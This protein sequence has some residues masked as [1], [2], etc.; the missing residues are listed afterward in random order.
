MEVG[1]DV[2]RQPAKCFF[3]ARICFRLKTNLCKPREPKRVK[4]NIIG[5]GPAGL[6]FAILA[7]KQHPE[8]KITV[9]ERNQPDDTFGFGVVFSDETLSFFREAD[10]ESYNE[11]IS[12]FAYWDEIETRY[13]GQVIRTS[14]HGFCGMSRK[15][16]LQILQNRAD[17]LGVTIH[18]ESEITDPSPYQDADLVVAADGVNSQIRETYAASFNPRIDFRPNKFVWLGTAAPF[19]AFTFIFKEDRNGIWN[20]HAYR[21]EDELATLIVETTEVTWK[22]AGMDTATEAETAQFIAEL[23]AEELNGAQVL[24]NRSNW[25]AFPNIHCESWVHENIVLIGDS[26]HTAHFSIGSGTKLA[27]EDAIALHQAC[28][29]DRDNITS[30][31]ARYEAVRREEVERIQHAANTSLTWFETVSRFWGMDARQFNFSMLTRSK[32]ITYENLSLRDPQLI[33]DVRDWFAVQAGSP[34]GTVPMFTYF[35]LRGMDLENRIVIS[36]MCQYS[37]VEGE[38]NDWH[39]VHLGSRCLG[40]AGLIFTEMTVVARDGRISH[41]CTGIYND[42]QCQAWKRIVNFVHTQ[43]RSKI[44]LQLGHA[45]RKGSTQLGWE[46]PDHPLENGNWPIMSASPLPYLPNSAIPR[47]MSQDDMD[48]LVAA[49]VR[50]AEYGL[51]ADFDMLEIHMAHGYLLASFISPLTNLRRDLYGGDIK[52]RMTLP[53]RVFRAVR[54]VW[55]EDRPISVRLS[56]TDW[57]EGGLSSEDLVAAA[58]M[59]KDAGCDLIDVSAG[60]TVPHQKPAYGR[61]FQTPFSDQIRNEVGISTIAVGNITTADQVNTILAAGRADLVALARPH[62]V[63]PHF[64]LQAAAHYEHEAQIW[65]HAYATAQLQAHAVA[66]RHRADMEELR[67]M[68]RPAKPSTTR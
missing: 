33:A 24:T 58:T 4:A 23:F 37:A 38:P 44:C 3:P 52:N 61:M 39:M 18:Y 36:P 57:H 60:Q 59:L 65:P 12:H 8:D 43:S 49:H 48:E 30:A 29:A 22:S 13:D 53:L 17:G 10:A 6:Y 20:V 66:G 26:A 34:P 15:C 27:M 56:A 41:G 21:Y 11:I 28:E 35:R 64:T 32:Q 47:E 45:G 62:L 40:G 19:E 46:N 63:N 67:R 68:A 25:R 14:G 16:L 2:R 9:F 7:K 51:E 50:A 1:I 31:P 54:V 55:P 42:K 5:G